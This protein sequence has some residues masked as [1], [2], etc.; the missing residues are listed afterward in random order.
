MA[1]PV[2]Q[3]YK[4]LAC[5]VLAVA[6]LRIEGKWKVYIGAVEGQNYDKEW[7]EVFKHGDATTKK[8]AC[9]IFP[10]YEEMP[11]AS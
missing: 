7:N 6:S 1:H 11:Y 5:K 10:E 3:T 2:T 9:A 8:I 4:A